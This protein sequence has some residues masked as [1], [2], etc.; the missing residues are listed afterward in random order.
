M[1]NYNG[2]RDV[3]L[4][5]KKSKQQKYKAQLICENEVNDTGL[6]GLFY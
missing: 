6:L 3:V 2:C 1:L 4:K 5:I